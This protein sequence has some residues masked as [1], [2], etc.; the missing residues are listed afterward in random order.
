MRDGRVRRS[1]LGLSGQTVPIDTR[2]RRFH[3]LQQGNGVLVLEALGGG[4]AAAAGL[5]AGDVVIRFDLEPIA[6]VDDLHRALTV[7]RAGVAIEVQVLRR[8]Q[9]VALSV[10][11]AEA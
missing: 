3:H 7:E 2:V 6:S 4:S 5:V 8:G 10:I 1:R 11:P 9:L